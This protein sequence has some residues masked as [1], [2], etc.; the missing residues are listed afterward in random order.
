[1]SRFQ[2]TS[3]SPLA[4][5]R[6]A[7]MASTPSTEVRIVTARARSLSSLAL[8][9]T[10]ARVSS[11]SRHST[12]KRS[13]RTGPVSWTCTGA[14]MPPGFHVAVEAVPVLEDAGDVALAA[15]ARLGGAGDLDRDDVFVADARERRDVEHVGHEVALGIAQ[16][17]AVEPHVGLVEDA[18][19]RD[20]ASAIASR[21]G[22]CEAFGGAGAGR[23]S[24]RTRDGVA[25][26]LAR[27]S[28][29]TPCRRHRDRSHHVAD[30]RRRV[31]PAT[32]RSGPRPE[33][34]DRGRPV[35]SPPCR[36]RPRRHHAARWR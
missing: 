24:R 26:D 8:S 31:S 9:R 14:Q 34:T 21:L 29:T 1:M 13:T 19:E 17:G 7:S 11:A 28:R 35:P 15:M 32:P 2:L 20:P 10:C 27:R 36:R 25:N 12:R 30:R 18:V 6:S 33:R 3:L 5:R 4:T 22:E 16:V 23:R